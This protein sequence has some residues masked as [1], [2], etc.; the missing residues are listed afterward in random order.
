MGWVTPQLSPTLMVITS[1]FFLQAPKSNPVA[2]NAAKPKTTIF[3][4]FIFHS[5][6]LIGFIMMIEWDG[7][8]CQMFFAGAQQFRFQRLADAGDVLRPEQRP[9]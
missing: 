3:D 2:H 8:F 4:N 7:V 1:D 9:F 6:N 5:L